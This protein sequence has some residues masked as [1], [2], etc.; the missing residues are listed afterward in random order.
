MKTISNISPE[1]WALPSITM[2]LKTSPQRN[3]MS[4][5]GYERKPFGRQVMLTISIDAWY[6]DTLKEQNI[7]NC[8]APLFSWEESLST[9]SSRPYTTSPPQAGTMEMCECSELVWGK[10][11]ILEFL[12][13]LIFKYFVNTTCN[14]GCTTSLSTT[15]P[16]ALAILSHPMRQLWG[17]GDISNINL[18]HGN[19]RMLQPMQA[20]SWR[21]FWWR[22]PPRSF[23]QPSSSELSQS[24]HEVIHRRSGPKP[25]L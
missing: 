14:S 10:S 15:R 21:T 24:S 23:W 16:S 12:F 17:V 7:C 6:D 13:E 8:R 1:P 20:R 5:K 25:F 22:F 9:C 18:N 3:Q 11:Y 2:T 4:M 19:S